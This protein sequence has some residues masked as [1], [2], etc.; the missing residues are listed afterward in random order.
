M[1]RR[2]SFTP[3]SSVTRQQIGGVATELWECEASEE[4]ARARGTT[5]A[6]VITKQ[7]RW[8]SS[9]LVVCHLNNE[10]ESFCCLI[11]WW[12]VMVR[13]VWG[14]SVGESVI[15]KSYDKDWI[16]KNDWSL[17]DD[18]PNPTAIIII[19]IIVIIIMALYWAVKRY[20]LKLIQREL[21]PTVGLKKGA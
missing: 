8:L 1:R 3:S 14:G 16:R 9:N 19:M 15:V 10:C 13:F 12:E 6:Q 21:G 11:W 4:I 5:V 20:G 17:N 7:Q 2:P 18:Q